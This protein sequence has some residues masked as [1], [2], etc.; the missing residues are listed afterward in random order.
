MLRVTRLVFLFA[1]I[2]LAGV[3]G[4]VSTGHAYNFQIDDFL[5]VKNSSTLFDDSFS[6]GNPPPSAPNFA[7][8]ASAAYGLN[9]G[10]TVG[11]EAGG[12]LTL[13]SSGAALAF[14]FNESRFNLVQ[15]VTL[16]TSQTGGATG[17]NSNSTFVVTGVFDLIIPGPIVVPGV[18]GDRYAVRL[19]DGTPTTDGTDILSVQVVR[20]S[21]GQLAIQF[22]HIDDAGNTNTLLE[23]TALN[24]AHDQIA[25][26]LSHPNATNNTIS[27]SFA[28]ID[29]GV[30]GPFT[31][32]G[33][34]F[35]IFNGET[36]TRA[37]FEAVTP[38]L[39]TPEPASML[40]LGC[41]LLLVMR[42]SRRS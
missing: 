17:L 28:Y 36:F 10:A 11:P 7:N 16:Q 3:F 4:L 15:R 42:F 29:S 37:Q 27:A 22:R 25:L 18:N 13:N 6:D 30:T 41:S 39:V 5:I 34:T 2:A 40:L 1:L 24:T 20:R 38:T 14:N 9:A 21:D 33:T 26:R 32:F 19:T 8:G 23:E 12:K 31:T 35:N